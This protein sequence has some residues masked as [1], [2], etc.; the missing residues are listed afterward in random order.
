MSIKLVTLLTFLIPAALHAQQNFFEGD[1]TYKATIRSKGKPYLS[2]KD[3]GK[4][5][6]MGDSWT[7]TCKNGNYKHH[8]EYVD[9][10]TILKDKKQYLKFRNFDTL[11]YVHYDFDTSRVLDIIKDPKSYK[12][13]SYDCKS[14]TIKTA[15]NSKQYFYTAALRFNPEYDKDNTIG[16]YNVYS[17]EADGDIYMLAH[18]EG[19]FATESDSCIKVTPRRVDDHVFDLPNLPV[20][21]FIPA[22]LIHMPMYRGG[23]K[24][25]MKY[26]EAN[27]DTRL[28]AKYVKIP[29][30]E[31]E[32]SAQV[33]VEFMVR[34]DGSLID[35][36]IV[37][38]KEV[39]SKLAK[40]AL[41][42]V[43]E[44]GRW[45]PAT[46]F[47]QKISLTMKQPVIFKVI[48]E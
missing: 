21:E 10:Y 19:S 14:M 35:F 24:A 22:E 28:A 27:L 48:Q 46:F 13:G 20:K 23:D 37:N 38:E 29:K 40:E 4:I 9:T 18:S 17:R 12:I 36:H 1:L 30:G 44:S 6:A 31:K 25:W 11:Y 42:V 43:T 8:N 32:A 7:M 45:E 16:Q 34:E 47:G 26:L 3:A 41:R 15:T 39:N 33:I 2:D 5:L